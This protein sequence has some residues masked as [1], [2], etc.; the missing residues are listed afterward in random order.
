MSFLKEPPMST[1][2]SFRLDILMSGRY[3]FGDSIAPMKG[4][5]SV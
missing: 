4:G 3:S 2:G 1:G 5:L